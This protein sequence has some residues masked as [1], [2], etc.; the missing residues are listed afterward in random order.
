MSYPLTKQQI[1][2]EIVQCGKDPTY[3]LN[4]YAKISHP[5]HGLIPFRTY[6]FQQQL[7]HVA[8][9]R[10]IRKVFDDKSATPR[11][12]HD[13]TFIDEDV[14]SLSESSERLRQRYPERYGFR[15]ERLDQD[16]RYA[17]SVRHRCGQSRARHAPARRRGPGIRKVSMPFQ[18]QIR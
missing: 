10:R 12:P 18:S 3:F 14:E 11:L 4:N 2:K 13:Q 1:L 17:I 7:L 8:Q 9:Y 5:M 15:I 16:S 6:D